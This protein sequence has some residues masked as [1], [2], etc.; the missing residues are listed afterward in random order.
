MT[1]EDMPNLKTLSLLHVG[2][3]ISDDEDDDDESSCRES[4]QDEDGDDEYT[5]GEDDETPDDE[6]GT[7][8]HY[9]RYV[10]HFVHE[11]VLDCG[12]A[13]ER[14]ELDAYCVVP[15]YHWKCSKH[16]VL[17]DFRSTTL[18]A[19]ALRRNDN[20]VALTLKYPYLPSLRSLC[21]S[22]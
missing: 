2:W 19:N 18:L 6:V 12:L 9:S 1:S 22:I 21:S 17:H 15:F 14:I 11:T 13:S 10:R 4:E 16:L 7:R 3:G 20:I 8:A 5:I